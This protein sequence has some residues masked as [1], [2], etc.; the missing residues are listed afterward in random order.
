MRI[1]WPAYFADPAS[2]SSIGAP[3]G[4]VH[5]ARSPMPLAA[6]RAAAERISGA[7]VDV[8][9]GASL[10]LVRGAGRGPGLAP[11]PDR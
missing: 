1:V 2:V 8:V 5:D 3:V 7:F 9:D 6:S 10:H 4:F 11:P